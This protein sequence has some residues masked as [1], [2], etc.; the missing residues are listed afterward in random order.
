M[1]RR[2]SWEDLVADIIVT[3]GAQQD[4]DLLNNLSDDESRGLTVTRVIGTIH[5]FSGTIAGAW[6]K[7][8][9]DMGIGVVSVDAV[10]ANA[11]PDPNLSQDQPPRGWLWRGQEMPEQNGV[12]TRIVKTIHFDVHGQR[13]L[14]AGRL[15]LIINSTGGTGTAFT[16]EMRVLMR[17][18]LL[19][20]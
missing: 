1:A 18:L 6:G 4:V 9:L 5:M 14:E 7:Q 17:S 16:T 13:R 2:T 8:I 11:F 19:L 20:P 15:M 10:A 3:S 12:G